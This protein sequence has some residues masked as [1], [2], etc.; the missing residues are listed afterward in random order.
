MIFGRCINKVLISESFSQNSFVVGVYVNVKQMSG[1]EEIQQS[2]AGTE[3]E[4]HRQLPSAVRRRK[5]NNN[6]RRE[7]VSINVCGMVYE[8]LRSTLE[9]F[10]ATLLGDV[11]RRTIY[12]EHATNSYF[13][14]RN[15][16]CFEAIL[17][18]YQSG[19]HLI[20]PPNIPMSYFLEELTFFDL[21]EDVFMN[22]KIKEGYVTE[23]VPLPKRY[24]QKRLWELLEHPESSLP[25]R[26]V[27]YVSMLV[28]ALSVAVLC[29][30]TMPYFNAAVAERHNC[31]PTKRRC[32]KNAKPSQLWQ[33]LE[34]AFIFWFTVEYFLRFVSSPSKCEFMKSFLNNIDL[35]AI[36]PFYIALTMN[37]QNQAT[38][39]VLRVV[40]L[41][42]VFRIFKL[43]RHIEGLQILG[44]TVMAS[45]SELGTLILSIAM[46][47]ILFSTGMY[48]T[49]KG[50]HGMFTSIPDGFWYSL[51]TM[52][53]V[54]YGDHWP[55]TSL[56]K[57]VGSVCV[58]SGVLTL[59]LPIPV[60]VAKFE[61]F[62]KKHQQLYNDKV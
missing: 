18:F 7:K 44:K 37:S 31:D 4:L 28:V 6:K 30:S 5:R 58:V 56:G 62:Y 19:G 52:T 59:A 29:M 3:T 16:Q 35:L 1:D 42:R 23:D 11:D 24:W 47:V 33:V 36:L 55:T 25:A 17:Y 40:R 20:R 45:V 15:R 43:S 9:R 57:L 13:F 41:V 8:T 38:I 22:L 2:P 61:Y 60:I 53:T 10:P 49:E 54:G 12:Y 14:N 48:Y 51:V 26:I 32:D 46:G 21:G 34:I 39:S 27:A 50:N